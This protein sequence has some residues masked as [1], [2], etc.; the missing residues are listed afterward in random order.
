M[1]LKISQEELG[2]LPLSTPVIAA[3]IRLSQLQQLVLAL[4]L[5]LPIP[6]YLRAS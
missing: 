3:V 2:I 5:I 1:K 4:T 6:P